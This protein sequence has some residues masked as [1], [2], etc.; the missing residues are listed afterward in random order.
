MF[1]TLTDRLG[2]IFDGLTKKGALKEAD[3]DTA[4]RQVRLGL[5]EADVALDVAKDFIAKAKERATGAE[6]MRSVT[7]G[8]LVIKIVH[9]L[10]VETLE[11]GR[12][13]V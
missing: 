5:L 1:E 6:I 2:G 12:A 7:P 9:D 3:I 4:L 8:Q 13:H 10:L 11:I